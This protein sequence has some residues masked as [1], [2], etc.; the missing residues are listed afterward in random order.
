MSRKFYETWKNEDGMFATPAEKL[1]TVD[2]AGMQ[3]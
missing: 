1:Q 3:R 2:L